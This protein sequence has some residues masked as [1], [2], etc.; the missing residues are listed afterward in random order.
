MSGAE[1][2][3]ESAAGLAGPEVPKEGADAIRE[4]LR[5][6]PLSSG[7][8]RMLGAKGEVLYVARPSASRSA[9]RPTCV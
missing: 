3:R 2:G 4:A 9:F 6:I 7:V 8:Y 1:Q 5:T